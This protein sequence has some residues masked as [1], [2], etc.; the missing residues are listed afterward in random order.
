MNINLKFYS[1]LHLNEKEEA[2]KNFYSNDFQEQIK[3]YLEMAITLSN[4]LKVKDLDFTLL[5]NQKSKIDT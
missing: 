3:T 5:T 2:A 1:L 4:S